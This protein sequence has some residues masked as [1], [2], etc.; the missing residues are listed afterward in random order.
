M[1][2]QE[3]RRFD[4]RWPLIAAV[5]VLA[6]CSTVDAAAYAACPESRMIRVENYPSA[7][8][9]PSGSII[10]RQTHGQP[11]EY[12]SSNHVVVAQAPAPPDEIL[13]FYRCALP[14][15]NLAIISE[16]KANVLLIRFTGAGIDDGSITLSADTENGGTRIEIFVIENRG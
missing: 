11:P 3:R 14:S 6:S 2:S 12:A 1:N 10:E 13:S 4:P 15:Q 8:I 5:L 7:L 9:L 16:E